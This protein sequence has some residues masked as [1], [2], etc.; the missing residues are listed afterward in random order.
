MVLINIQIVD[1][2]EYFKGCFVRYVHP[3]DHNP[4]RIRKL[5]EC[6]ILKIYDIWYLKIYGITLVAKIRDIQ[7]IKKRAALAVGYEKYPIYVSKKVCEENHFDLNILIEVKDKKHYVLIK[8]L[9][10]SCIRFL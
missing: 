4:R 1:D 3:A 9:I 10:H 2:N 5:S 8:D 7:K 6:L